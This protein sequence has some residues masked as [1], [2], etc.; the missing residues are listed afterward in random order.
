VSIEIEIETKRKGIS[1]QWGPLVI[2]FLLPPFLLLV[3]FSS[4][5]QEAERREREARAR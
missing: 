1:M 4:V 2:A 3:F 5:S